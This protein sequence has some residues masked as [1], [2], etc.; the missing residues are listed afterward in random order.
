VAPDVGDEAPVGPSEGQLIGRYR[1]LGRLGAGGMGIVVAASD[2]E[3]G[4]RVAIKVLRRDR[5]APGAK[6]VEHT[7]R[8]DQAGRRRNLDREQ[9]LAEARAVA[10]VSHL[11]LVTIFEVGEVNGQIF[12][13]MEYVEGETLTRWLEK[14]RSVGDVLDVFVQAGRGLAAVHAAGLVHGD[15]KP[16]NALVDRT[17]RVRVIDFG[18][19]RAAAAAAEGGRPVGTPRY[20]APEQFAGRPVDSRA[21]QFAFCVA[22]YEALY[23]EIP[24]PAAACDAELASRRRA[25]GPLRPAS[26][27]GPRAL[28]RAVLRG[29]ARDPA[30]R[31]ASMDDLLAALERVVSRKRALQQ[32]GVAVA[33][34]VSAVAAALS[35]TGGSE[36]DP[37]ESVDRDLAGVWDRVADGRIRAAFTASSRPHAASSY[38]RA[39]T[40]LHA[41]AGAWTR[42]R[43][44][45]CRAARSGEESPALRD[46]R[47]ACLDRR[48][49]RL[50]ALVEMLARA[51]D[52]IVDRALEATADLE[53]I[54]ACSDG[55]AL[56]A[57]PPPSTDP[58]ARAELAALEP[59]VAEAE[60]TLLAGRAADAERALGPL[61]ARARALG[62][63]PLIASI[64]RLHGRALED[65]DRAAEARD[66]LFES[67]GA[68]ERAGLAPAAAD[69]HVDLIR[70][71]GVRLAQHSEARLL[72]R[73]AGAA[74]ERSATREDP[75]RRA[76]LLTAEGAVEME[77]PNLPRSAELLGR[78]LA[79]RRSNLPADHPDI[80]VS[81][82][83]L[84][85]CLSRQA[86]FAE[87]RAHLEAATTFRRRVF[88]D[89]HPLTAS[90]LIDLGVALYK[91]GRHDDARDQFR[92]ALAILERMPELRGYPKVLNNL[93][94]L[95]TKAG[96]P[97]Q[98]IRYHEA[99]LA[100]RRT[101]LGPDHPEVASSLYNLG[102]AYAELGQ[103]DRALQLLQSA[104]EIDRRA[105]GEEHGAYAGDV[106]AVADILRRLGRVREA[107]EMAEK[108]LGLLIRE[109]GT[110]HPGTGSARMVMGAAL[111]ARRRHREAI[112]VLERSIELLPPADP[113]QAMAKFHLAQALAA[114]GKRAAARALARDAREQLS[115]GGQRHS[116]AVVD[117]W[118]A[119]AGGR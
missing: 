112:P 88:G 77:V 100:I 34:A 38:E 64:A 53:P 63:Q 86:R 111:I 89:H 17:G 36:R 10:Q 19:A 90:A 50:G 16:D 32:L 62:N 11:N 33:L 94:A 98:A 106:V 73:A 60:V 21:D 95:E 113:D 22:L 12:L 51:D 103:L 101:R 7:V 13:A 47:G 27:R 54:E 24:F 102:V 97:E 41:Y 5:P 92:A 114:T 52:E 96:R 93:A 71:V 78:A 70:V 9:L 8:L 118:L 79:L 83:S 99:A 108:G 42:T 104:L 55:E 115:R 40:A 57:G 69:A 67:V 4:R 25:L 49:L 66:A 76:A 31:F 58:A 18:L 26:H 91:E 48:R 39:R 75:S 74:L 28:E 15:F 72:A 43:R 68:A 3:L 116:I 20:M 84:G 80:A 56:L 14:K 29:L 61:L 46:R 44:S 105:L 35:L 107:L 119:R 37:C 81:E 110:D 82:M 117:A 45:A 87:A 6:P 65:L 1:V 30:A 59:K 85:T 23:G 109:L 2:P